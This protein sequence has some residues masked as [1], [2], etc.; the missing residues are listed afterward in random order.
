MYALSSQRT[1]KSLQ[2][3]SRTEETAFTGGED[4]QRL[5][6]TWPKSSTILVVVFR[7]TTLSHVRVGALP[8]QHDIKHLC[9]TSIKKSP[10]L[11]PACHA[12]PPS[13]TDSRYCRAG[14]AGVGVNS[15]MGV[16]ARKTK[17]YCV[18]S[19]EDVFQVGHPTCAWDPGRK[20]VTA[21]P[22]EKQWSWSSSPQRGAHYSQAHQHLWKPQSQVHAS[23]SS[24]L[25]ASLL[26]PWNKVLCGTCLHACHFL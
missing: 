17:K 21:F 14:N 6:A 16:S 13:S 3:T 7:T 9:P 2:P 19:L 15:S 23:T 11:S 22:F 8:K 4:T 26:K 25:L 12:T 10:V 20:T 5:Q 18:V 24:C 1:M